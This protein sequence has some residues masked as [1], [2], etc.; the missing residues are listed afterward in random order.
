MPISTK[1]ATATESE[2]AKTPERHATPQIQTKVEVKN[3]F[4]LN[5]V[6]NNDR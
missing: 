2:L 1:T 5:K 6:S 3:N 4:L